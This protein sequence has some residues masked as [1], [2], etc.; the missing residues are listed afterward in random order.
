MS[1]VWVA[2]VGA[3]VGAGATMYGANKQSKDAAHA[4]DVN[5]AS[6]ASAQRDNW[7][8]YLMTR[9]VTPGPDTQNGEVPGF[10]PGAVLNTRLPL[11][12]RVTMPAQPAPATPTDPQGQ[13]LPFLIKKGS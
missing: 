5:L 6:N 3:V 9:G 13:P 11:W 7:L 12:A 4:Q 1:E 8:H 10:A 2:A